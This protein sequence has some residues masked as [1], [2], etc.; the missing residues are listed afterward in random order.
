MWRF[1]VRMMAYAKREEGKC[2]VRSYGPREATG[3][4]YCMSLYMLLLRS[5]SCTAD[6]QRCFDTSIGLG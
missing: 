4:I 5:G 3:L 6:D 2:E 1:E